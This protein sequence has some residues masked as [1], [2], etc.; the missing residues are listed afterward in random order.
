MASQ[1][2]R[3]KDA[4]S[5]VVD[6]AKSTARSVGHNLSDSANAAREQVANSLDAAA[7]G[8]DQKSKSAPDTA[9][10]Y[11]RKAQ[12]TLHGAAG[13]VRENDVRQMGQDAADTARANPLTSLFVLSAVVVGG[14]IV[15]AALV[16]NSGRPGF[17]QETPRVVGLSSSATGIGRKG[18]E[19]LSRIRDAAFSLALSKAVQ[20]VDDIFPGFREHYERA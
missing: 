17:S 7:D 12:D 1:I 15:V 2:E 6:E 4:A 19:T 16:R 20:A 9:K 3:A 14:G 10:R 5:Q 11:A 13:Y 18:T 8:L